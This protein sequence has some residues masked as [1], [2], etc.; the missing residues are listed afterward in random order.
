M[1]HAYRPA[2]ASKAWLHNALNEFPDVSIDQWLAPARRD[3]VTVFDEVVRTFGE[4]IDSSVREKLRWDS[5]ATESVAVALRSVGTYFE[6]A[7][8]A[9]SRSTLIGGPVYMLDVYCA[10]SPEDLI[11]KR[12][13]FLRDV[14]HKA[15]GNHTDRIHI[16]FWP[17]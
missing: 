13:E 4:R 14:W 16:A 1:T 12:K 3:D 7:Q 6:N 10:I 8:F 11:A 2:P 17:R 5:R 9:L 15:P